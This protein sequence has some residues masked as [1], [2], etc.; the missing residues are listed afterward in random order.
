MHLLLGGIFLFYF[1]LFYFIL[2]LFIYLFIYLFYHFT[3][4]KTFR[5]MINFF[6]QNP[7]IF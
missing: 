7:Y 2:F 6:L 4:W 3:T 1:I 5:V